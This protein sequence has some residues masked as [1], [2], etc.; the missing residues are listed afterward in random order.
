MRSHRLSPARHVLAFVAGLS[1]FVS[2]AVNALVFTVD[3]TSDANLSDC[4][5]AASD[6]SLRGAI[7]KANLTTARDQIQFDIPESDPGYQLDSQHWRILVGATA[8]PLLSEAIDIDG[9]T[10]PGATPGT[11]S[12]DQGGLDAIIKIELIPAQTASNQ[13]VGLDIGLA[14][15]LM[16]ASTV[17][18]LAIGGFATQIQ[19]AGGSAHAVEGCFLGTSPSG[20]APTIASPT[21]STTAIRIQGPGPYRIGGLQ[22]DQRNLISGVRNAINWF[23]ASDGVIIQGNQFGTNAAG[24]EPIRIHGDG[25]GAAG[26]VT[27]ARIGDDTDAGRN[28]FAAISFSAL[29]MFGQSQSDF[30]G[31]RI[32]GNWFGTDRTGTKALGNGLNPQSPS[33]KQ[34]TIHL[35]GS[36]CRLNIGGLNPGEPNRIAFG[37]AAGILV[38]QCRGLSAITNEFIGN[39][40]IP[41]DNT[42]GGGAVGPTTNDPDD[43]DNTGGNRLQNYPELALPPGFAPSGS[44][45]VALQYQVD[46]ATSNASYPLT[47]YFYRGAC[48]GGSAALL[49]SDTYVSADAQLLR[50]FNLQSGDG[51]NVLPLVVQ[52]V[53]AQ[54]NASEFAPMIGDRIFGDALEDTPADDP[55]GSCPG[56]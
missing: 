36:N 12:P 41:I 46:T 55:G 43:A 21:A 26:P 11:Q 22:P 8:L 25:L 48:G 1:L 32:I 10:Q 3:T 40:L 34:A 29:R 38:D 20:T 16:A 17:R 28:L 9:Y 39:Q 23:V 2:N 7:T 31:T 51:G 42:F 13:Q 56:T 14:N 54:G 52:A 35:S 27:N 44:D 15:F 49:A 47:V 6:C 5:A 4:T 37:G 45:Q 19:L 53:D 50:N 18:G 30:N 33:Q 24:T